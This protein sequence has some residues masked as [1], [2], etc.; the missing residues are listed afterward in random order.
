MVNN[1]QKLGRRGWVH[2][3]LTGDFLG[4][5]VRSFKAQEL[6]SLQSHAEIFFFNHICREKNVIDIV[7]KLFL[8]RKNQRVTLN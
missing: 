5:S 8:M 1:L 7:I 6:Y 3:H 2:F 4:F